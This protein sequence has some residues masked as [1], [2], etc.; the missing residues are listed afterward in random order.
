MLPAIF[1]STIMLLS[2]LLGASAPSKVVP[3]S[4][5]RA[6]FNSPIS[7]DAFTFSILIES[8]VNDETKF[9]SFANPTLGGVE[10]M[11][12]GRHDKRT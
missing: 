7:G 3:K 1:F 6:N 9:V 11:Y 5:L 4:Y 8:E 12:F 10:L 2:L